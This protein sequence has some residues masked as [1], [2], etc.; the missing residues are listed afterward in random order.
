MLLPGLLSTRRVWQAQIEALSDSVEIVVPELFGQDSIGAMADAALASV[1]GPFALAGFSMGGYVAFEMFRRASRRIE[2]L[3][4]LDTQ[5]EA[6]SPESTARRRGFI[7]QS[8]VG[9]FKGVQPRLLPALVHPSNLANPA[10]VQPLL[11]MAAAIGAEGFI[12]EQV[13]II[14]RPDSRPLLRSI[15]VPTVVIVGRQDQV[16]P[17][18]RAEGM[19][20]DIPDARLV[21]IEEGGHMSPLEKPAEVTAALRKWLD[22]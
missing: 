16:T 19:A 15:R 18:A 1:P 3:A 5:A 10:V 7:E 22:P 2:R 11:E 14:G 13:A 4:L 6:D 8:K 21:V 20:A 17:L 12:R 9:Q